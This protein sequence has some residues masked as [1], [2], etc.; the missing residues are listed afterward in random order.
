[1]YGEEHKSKGLDFPVVFLCGLS[2]TFNMT[3]V[4]KQVLCHKELGLGLSHTNIAQRVR[5]PT[6]AKRAISTKIASE[7]ISEELR[8]LYVAMTRARDR[9]IMT[10]AAPKLE[11]RLKEIV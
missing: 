9:L 3:D 6:I 4:Q 8:V 7:T 2:R 10:Y 1:M 5:F 11:D